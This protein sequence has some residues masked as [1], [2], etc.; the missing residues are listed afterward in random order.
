L[1]II[2]LIFVNTYK[3]KLNCCNKV[4]KIWITPDRNLHFVSEKYGYRVIQTQDVALAMGCRERARGSI[5]ISGA[6]LPKAS[7]LLCSVRL[8]VEYFIVGAISP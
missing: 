4:L 3:F 5:A 7:P 6:R 1:E 8:L 2:F